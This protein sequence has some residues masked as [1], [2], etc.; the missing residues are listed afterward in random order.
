VKTVSDLLKTKGNEIWST[1]PDA[2]VYEALQAMAEKNV[3]A[4]LVLEGEKIVGI[5]SER[6]YARKLVLEG[7][8]AHTTPVRAVMT[9]AVIGI[10]Q[11]HSIDE[12]MAL[13]SDRRIRHLP[14]LDGDR[15]IGIVSIGDVVKEVIQDQKFTIA[16]LEEYIT[17]RR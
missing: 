4:L 14:V 6:D 17:G 1:T 16:L 15:V 10:G 12:C 9:S 3:G 11:G 13:M 2:S 5:F 7:K 8:S